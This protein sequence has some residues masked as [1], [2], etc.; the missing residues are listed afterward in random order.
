MILFLWDQ[1]HIDLIDVARWVTVSKSSSVVIFWLFPEGEI[2]RWPLISELVLTQHTKKGWFS[3]TGQV[4][5]AQHL[6]SLKFYTWGNI[7]SI[8]S[9]TTN[10]LQFS[11]GLLFASVYWVFRVNTAM[12]VVCGDIGVF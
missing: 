8:G 12:A 6:F 3:W 9:L 2:G 1:V 7:E 5:F 11:A 4:V 10:D